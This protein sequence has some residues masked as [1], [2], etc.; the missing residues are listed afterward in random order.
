MRLNRTSKIELLASGDETRPHMLHP[1]LDVEA[2]A[3]VATDGHRLIKHP[4]LLDDGD[5]SAFVSVAA[6]KAARKLG[7]KSDDIKI[8]VGSKSLTLIDGSV[9]PTPESDLSFPP[10][11]KVIPNYK[12][13]T[14]VTVGLDAKYLLE[15]CQAL[16]GS[17]KEGTSVCLS[18]PLPDTGKDMLDPIV[19]GYGLSDAVAVLMPS[20]PAKK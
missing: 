9:L 18:F 3:L 5:E 12:G 1:Y 11:E 4:V 16:G 7:L 17:T 6:I 2:K 15:I 10:Y 20:R 13:R 14:M 19:V 8:K